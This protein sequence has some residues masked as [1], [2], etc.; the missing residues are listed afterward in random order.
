M[1]K[2]KL[3][4]RPIAR[5]ISAHYQWRQLWQGLWGC[6]LLALLATALWCAVTEL[7]LQGNVDLKAARG[8]G[9]AGAENG[10]EGLFLYYYF[11]PRASGEYLYAD[12][13]PF[14]FVLGGSLGLFAV[15]RALGWLLRWFTGP[16]RLRKYLRS[17]DSIAAAAQTIADPGMEE[18]RFLDVAE[19][20]DHLNAAS[21]DAKLSLGGQMTELEE[22]VNSLIARMHSTY[23]QQIR[24]VDDASHELRTPIAVIQGYVNMLDRWGKNDEK[25]LQEAIS[26][27]QTESD[28]MKT[29]VDQLLFL[30]RGDM[31][32][33]QF[34]KEPVDLA[35]MLQ[36][37]REESRLIDS[38]HP[39]TLQI[40]APC[41]LSADPAM[42]KQAVRI[43]VDNAAKYTPE[44]GAISLRLHEEPGSVL[45]S[46]QDE[47]RG[48][49]PKDAEHVFE[50]FY[51]ADEARST[52]G[53]GLGLSIAK[54]IVDQHGGVLRLVSYENMGSR[55]TIVLPGAK[56]VA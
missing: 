35:E 49:A 17:V 23:R 11:A 52:G 29:L 5:R 2:K 8:F 37:I 55:F 20:I 45:I 18:D 30:A 50:R 15:W 19:A 16:V 24:F 13:L 51:R 44:N 3:P 10:P 4:S 34:H 40:D 54:W 25:V 53:S 38:A 26:A 43:L 6:V 21:P 1:T 27:I 48:I 31:G 36:E 42:L 39:Y 28:H 33:Q 9:L 47:G 46:V 7:S 56:F 14:F 12:A 41:T 32:R 22:A